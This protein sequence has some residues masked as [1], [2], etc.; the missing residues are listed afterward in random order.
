MSE[1][2]VVK[3]GGEGP[4]HIDVQDLTFGYAGREVREFGQAILSLT[5]SE[6]CAQK[7][8]HAIDKWGAMLTH[9]CQ[10]CWK[11]SVE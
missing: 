9:W 1:L 7:F 6:A 10:W 5:S 11:V 3:E 4:Q 8:E 2:T